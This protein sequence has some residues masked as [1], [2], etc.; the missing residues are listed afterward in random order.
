[1][2]TYLHFTVISGKR[3]FVKGFD[4]TVDDEKIKKFFTKNGVKVTNI[5]RKDGKKP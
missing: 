4:S 5:E 1:M 2:P 3:L